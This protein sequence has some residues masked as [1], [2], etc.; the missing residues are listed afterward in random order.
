MRIN[1]NSATEPYKYREQV[2]N[3]DNQ[4][5]YVISPDTFT[6]HTLQNIRELFYKSSTVMDIPFAFLNFEYG[7]NAFC[8]CNIIRISD[9]FITDENNFY[10]VKNVTRMFGMRTGESKPIQS[11]SA[12]ITTVT[13]LGVFIDKLKETS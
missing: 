13:N 9:P 1:N 2:K 12:G 7:D 10:N 8:D 4:N 5:V 6:N 3:S 11:D